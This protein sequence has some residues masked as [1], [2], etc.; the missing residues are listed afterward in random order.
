[1]GPESAGA[2]PGPVCYDQ[3]GEEPTVTDADL[4]L[5]YLNPDYFLGGTMKLNKEKATRV[6]Q[7]KVAKPL[8]IDLLQACA[9]IYDIVNTNMADLIRVR[10]VQRGYDPR[11]TVLFA[12]GGAGPMHAAEYGTELGVPLIVIPSLAPVFSAF[13]SIVSDIRHEYEVSRYVLFPPD[14]ETMN[15]IFEALEA[16]AMD[17]L[18]REGIAEQDRELR[19]E[20]DIRYGLQI[21]EVRVPLPSRRLTAEDVARLPDEF[22]KRYEAIYGKATALPGGGMEVAKFRVVAVGK[23]QRPELKEYDVGPADASQT[24]KQRREVFFKKEGGFVQTNIYAGDQ[25]KAGHKMAGPAVIEYPATTVIV[26]PGKEAEIDRYMN[27]LMR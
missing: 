25:L 18:V 10:T 14:L 1:V 24:I 6:L 7:E 5:G 20:I 9:G 11:D 22:T 15:S 23:I 13:G 17:D 26:P 4:A 19:R 12:Y 3:G 8:N 16:R 21:W 2:V 27:V